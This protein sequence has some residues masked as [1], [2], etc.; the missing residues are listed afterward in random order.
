MLA[1]TYADSFLETE[2]VV[3]GLSVSLRCFK[4]VPLKILRRKVVSTL[5]RKTL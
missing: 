3:V 2:N 5:E 1:V 4:T